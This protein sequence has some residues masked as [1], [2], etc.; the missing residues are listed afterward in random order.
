MGN[1]PAGCTDADIDD[2]FGPD[3]EGEEPE[4]D[5]AEAPEIE[6]D[7][8]YCSDAELCGP[9]RDAAIAERAARRAA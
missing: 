6:W 5:E 3:Y 7:G 9:C 8:C 4:I 1:Y 2:R